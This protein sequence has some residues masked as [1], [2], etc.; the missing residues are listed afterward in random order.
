MIY[1][2][3]RSEIGSA[4]RTAHDRIVNAASVEVQLATFFSSGVKGAWYARS[5]TGS[6]FAESA[7]FTQ[8]SV[9]GA[10][11]LG[12]SLDQGGGRGTERIVNGGFGSDLT[13]WRAGP[14]ISG[15]GISWVAGKLRASNTAVGTNYERGVQDLVGLTVGM[16]Y[17]IKAEVSVVAGTPTESRITVI[18]VADI[19]QPIARTSV[20]AVF[21]ATA[22]THTLCFGPRQVGSAVPVVSDWDNISVRDVPGNYQLQAS[23][24][25]RPLYQASPRRAVFDGVDDVLNTTFPAALGANCTVGRA[26]PGTGAVITSGVN[27]GTSFADNVTASALLIAD[28]AL[29]A[30]ETALWTAY[31][32]QQDLL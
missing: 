3:I 27:V 21:R 24:G 15:G 14:V 1:G 10:V 19:D 8:S 20:N 2:A 9:G 16:L 12:L 28:R 17:E 22:T 7:G 26:I 4:I 31:L 5:N 23:A 18:G 13:G 25:L 30:G 6:V 32:N 29:T 11:G